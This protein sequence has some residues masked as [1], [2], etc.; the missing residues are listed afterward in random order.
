MTPVS[1]KHYCRQ[2]GFTADNPEKW[3]KIVPL[4]QDIDKQYKKKEEKKKKKLRRKKTKKK[5][6]KKKTRKILKLSSIFS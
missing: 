1:K 3:A 4:M 5:T 2:T 6:K